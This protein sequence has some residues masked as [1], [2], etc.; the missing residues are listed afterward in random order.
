MRI[1]WVFARTNHDYSSVTV[2]TS[3]VPETSNMIYSIQGH[4]LAWLQSEAWV[5][6]LITSSLSSARALGSWLVGTR[7]MVCWGLGVMLF[8][9]MRVFP[10]CVSSQCWPL[11]GVSPFLVTRSLLVLPSS[12]GRALNSVIHRGE[13]RALGTLQPIWESIGSVVNLTTTKGLGSTV[14]FL[15]QFSRPLFL[16]R[17]PRRLRI[18]LRYRFFE[19]CNEGLD[20]SWGIGQ[21][22]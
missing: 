12:D 11:G 20:T 16:L 6:E 9:F 8:L 21:V 13:P 4:G 19:A 3:D 10:C 2:D 7:S 17:Y 5:W 1:D 15:E 18:S 14:S 22:T